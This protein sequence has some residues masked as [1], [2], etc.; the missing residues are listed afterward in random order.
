MKTFPRKT[1]VLAVLALACTTIVIAQ[2]VNTAGVSPA[3][4]DAAA[5]SPAA[6]TGTRSGLMSAWE[7]FAAGGPIG[8]L[9]VVVSIAA[10]ALAVEHF[11]TIRRDRVIPSAL[12]GQ[13]QEL[14]EKG[15]FDQARKAAEADASLLGKVILAGL[16]QIGGMFGWFDIQSSMQ[17]AAEAEVSKLYRKLEYLT[18]IAGAAPML[19]LLGTVTGM[20]VAFNTIAGAEGGAKPSELAGGIAQALVTTCEGLVIAIPAMFFV[21]FFRNRIDSIVAEAGSICERLMA[22][23]RRGQS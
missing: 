7:L 20:I 23:F 5:A 16:G 8:L 15:E 6:D 2:N 21:G 18:F 17:E 3:G 10:T 19:G 12:A 4:A 14:I 11:L 9:L 22:R 13:L 1:L